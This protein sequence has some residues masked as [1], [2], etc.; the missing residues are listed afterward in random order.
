[1]IGAE[2][3]TFLQKWHAYCTDVINRNDHAIS[4]GVIYKDRMLSMKWC[5]L[6]RCYQWNDATGTQV[7]SKSCAAHKGPIQ[8]AKRVRGS[9]IVSKRVIEND[10]ECGSLNQMMPAVHHSYQKAATHLNNCQ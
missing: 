8:E 9:S 4:G 3:S 1:M 2:P 10:A 6:Y 7:I 5:L